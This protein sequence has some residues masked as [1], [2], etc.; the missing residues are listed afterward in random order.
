MDVRGL[1]VERLPHGVDLGHVHSVVRANRGG[2][3]VRI[4]GCVVES[5]GLRQAAVDVTA[6]HVHHHV[7]HLG[8]GPIHEREGNV[9]A[10]MGVDATPNEAADDVVVVLHRRCPSEA[11]A[12]GPEVRGRDGVV[13]GNLKHDIK[14]PTVLHVALNGGAVN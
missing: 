7:A 6:V 9:G 10:E 8:V 3:V 13:A 1:L 12:A 5:A 11:P 2:A 14:I 4:G